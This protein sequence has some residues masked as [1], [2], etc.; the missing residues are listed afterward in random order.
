MAGS[1]VQRQQELDRKRLTKAVGRAGSRR[2][3]TIPAVLKAPPDLVIEV[4]CQ[5]HAKKSLVFGKCTI[6]RFLVARDHG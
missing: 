1:P 5:R 3:E 4:L 6:R 2:K